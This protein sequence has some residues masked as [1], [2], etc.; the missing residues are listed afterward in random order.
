VAERYRRQILDLFPVASSRF[1]RAP[2]RV[3]PIPC[4][5]VAR[6][7]VSLPHS[8]GDGGSQPLSCAGYPLSVQHPTRDVQRAFCTPAGRVWG[9]PGNALNACVR[10]TPQLTDRTTPI[11]PRRPAP[12]YFIVDL[13]ELLLGHDWELALIRRPVFTPGHAPAPQCVLPVAELEIR[14]VG[15]WSFVPESAGLGD[16]LPAN[17]RVLQAQS[18]PLCTGR[19]TVCDPAGGGPEG[20]SWYRCRVHPAAKYCGRGAQGP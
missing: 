5:F 19:D 14:P 18:R 15:A 4:P 10:S 2:G 16:R 12:Q 20:Q 8:I 1:I 17:Y 7:T 3:R 9:W 13:C 11:A 6:G